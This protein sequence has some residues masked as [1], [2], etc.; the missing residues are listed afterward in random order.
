[1][2]TIHPPIPMLV[3]PLP[4][5]PHF[6]GREAELD[7]LRQAKQNHFRGVMALVGL[8]GSGKTALAARFLEELL[9][10][11]AEPTFHGVFVWSFYQ[12]PDA[13]LFLQ[14]AY[15]Y[16][17]LEAEPT[18]AKGAGLIHLLHAALEQGGPNFLLLD[19]LERV[20]QQESTGNYGR[21]DDPLLRS[22]LIRITEGLGKTTVLVTSRFP[23]TDLESVSGEA[24]Q[25]LSVG[26][27]ERNAAQSLLL[28]RGV[29]GD[30]NA[31][32]KLIE[33][34]GAHA[35]TLD[36]LGGLLGQFLDG[37]PTR[38]PELPALATSSGDRQA[39][40][41]ARLLRAYEEHLP[42][43]ELALLCRLCL[44]RRSMT[45]EQIGHLFLCQPEVHA[46]T[47]RELP[48]LIQR[49]LAAQQSDPD[50]VRDLAKS[51][52]ETV[53]ELLSKAPIAG[54]EESFRHEM[55]LLAE[56]VF[57]LQE[58]PMDFTELAH[59]YAGKTLEPATDQL[60]L[61]IS[62]R[63]DLAYFHDRFLELRWHPAMPYKEAP[64][65]FE[66][67]I[68]GKGLAKQPPELLEKSFLQLGFGK[69]GR[70]VLGKEA[71]KKG[72]LGEEAASVLRAFVRVQ[73]RLRILA[74]IHIALVRVRE[75]CRLLQ[76][77]WSL[78]GCLAPLDMNGMRQVLDGLVSRHL[79]LREANGSFSVHPAVR[80]HFYRLATTIEGGAWHDIL[81]E[82]LISL[83]Q[84]PGHGLPEDPATLD[85]VEEGIYHALEAGRQKEA[86][87]LYQ[88]VM[89]GLRHLA[90]KLGEMAR[91]LQI[92]RQFQP[93]PDPWSLGWFL[94]AL[95]E[96]E[97]AYRHNNLP[98]FRADIRLL[99]G[100][101]PQVA[102]EQETTRTAQA[103][104]L[105]GKTTIL[106]SE[107]LGAA[108]P[109]DQLLLY[110]GRFSLIQQ[111][112]LLDDYYHE[113]GWESDRARCLL[114]LAETATRQGEVAL[115]KRH[116]ETASKWILH[117]GSV[118]HLCSMH[119]VRA[120]VERLVRESESARRAVEE[121]LHM[122]RQC[123][124]GLHLVELLCEQVEI[125]MGLN[126]AMQAESV[127]RE[128]LRL[129]SH[130]D[131]QFAWGAAEAGHLLGQA[132]QVQKK[133]REARAILDHA[134]RVRRR[135]G[136]PRAEETDRLLA[137]VSGG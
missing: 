103:A 112:N 29:K 6:V 9:R 65:E 56:T 4:P 63:E 55:R 129:A 21:V 117:S 10:S 54:P 134:L 34:Y 37:D 5:A 33:T 12:E 72:G 40:R 133:Y 96:F 58:F 67:I 104:F 86:Y 1:M 121:G 51:I 16:F 89:G 48:E 106:P 15:E 126:E 49:R 136:H 137:L 71:A 102:T 36:H 43:A 81:R 53:T 114:V 18:P 122:A 22:L 44:L 94:R 91:G 113:I 99:Q 19:G 123:S 85:L 20:Q 70:G 7:A 61:S 83:A 78:A 26:G 38:A 107:P 101:L 77:K 128:A 14:Q 42:Q 100:R 60:P 32:A 88:N 105:M 35:L 74:G 45:T 62:N 92:L 66:K 2:A 30:E 84:R 24:Y 135:I 8:G 90:W 111:S 50:Y 118:E 64:S 31:L 3:H 98:Y 76:R 52:Q 127:A 59:L 97:E 69:R 28:Q 27:L 47:V 119:L 131:C 73:D 132:L 23:L 125:F 108:I 124:L 93:C 68:S 95:G 120:R 75:L 79:V 11:E 39:L 57:Q 46:R 41:L 110:L 87:D 115:G 13:G 130:A 109:R 25:S 17:S 82:Q 80:D 116:L